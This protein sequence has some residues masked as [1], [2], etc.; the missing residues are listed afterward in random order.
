VTAPGDRDQCVIARAR[1]L[2]AIGGAAGVRAHTG[3]EDT[4][5]AYVVAFGRAQW[6]IGELLAIIERPGGG[7]EETRRLEAIRGLLARFNWEHD[8]RQLALEAIERIAD[9]DEDRAGDLDDL[10]P[11]CT[12]C[13]A[14][15]GIFIG[16]GDA[17]LHYTGQGTAARPVELYDAGHAPV[18]AWRPASAQ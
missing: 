6:A 18:V 12:A 11:Y 3:D 4:R 5:T 13:G 7:P 8:D 10:E 17:W 16:H 2:A 1:E 14:D 9:G 15:V